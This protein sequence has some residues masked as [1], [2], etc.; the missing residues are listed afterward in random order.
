MGRRL[1]GLQRMLVIVNKLKG[2][3]TYVS[4]DELEKYV[5][6]CMENRG[7]SSVHFRTLERDLN[8]IFV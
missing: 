6:R 3:Q 8:E 5:A 1:E 2:K 4:K 7:Y